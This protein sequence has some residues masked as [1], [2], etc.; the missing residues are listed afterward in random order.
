M[1]NLAALFPWLGSALV[2]AVIMALPAPVLAHDG[3]HGG[4]GF[5]P[6]HGA[7]LGLVAI[8]GVAFVVWLLRSAPGRG[9]AA[10]DDGE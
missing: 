3:P 10:D 6:W 4:Q 5:S 7:G 2:L 1:R 9:E 8:A